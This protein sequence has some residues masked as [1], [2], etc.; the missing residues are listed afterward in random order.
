M[1][2]FSSDFQSGAADLLREFGDEVVYVA[3]GLPGASAGETVTAMVQPMTETMARGPGGS[4]RVKKCWFTFSATAISGGP[5]TGARLR[6]G[7]LEFV[8]REV[9]R[10]EGG[11]YVCQGEHAAR[12]VIRAKEQ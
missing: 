3:A 5:L 1:S 10:D 7:G 4:V 11:M 6:H 9:K 2:R 12:S 8:V